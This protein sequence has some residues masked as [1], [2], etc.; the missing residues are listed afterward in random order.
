[1]L[2]SKSGHSALKYSLID[3]VLEDGREEERFCPILLQL[4]SSESTVEK[5][6][7]IGWWS[8]GFA[9]RRFM[10]GLIAVL[11]VQVSAGQEGM[12]L[13]DYATL[14]ESNRQA[15]SAVEAAVDT[16]AYQDARVSVAILRRN[17]QGLVP[18]WSARE[19]ADAIGIVREGV[20]RLA[21]LEELLSRTWDVPEMP[22]RQATEELRG[23]VCAAC[24]DG[25][26]EGDSESGFRFRE[27]VF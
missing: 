13:E 25:Y 20:D 8:G 27:G 21:A 11:V 3:Y 6:I 2:W 12:S 15:F 5:H 17:F 24:H 18:F 1:L 14:M 7:A 9:M 4:R 16:A 22:V 10:I 19:R 26:R 23:A